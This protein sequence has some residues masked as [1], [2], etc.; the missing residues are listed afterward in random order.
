MS[1]DD[2]VKIVNAALAFILA[3]L[4][5]MAYIYFTRLGISYPVPKFSSLMGFTIGDCIV[6]ALACA[7]YYRFLSK[8]P[9]ADIL[10]VFISLMLSLCAMALG[11]IYKYG[12]ASLSAHIKS[13]LFLYII[14]FIGF[15]C[16]IYIALYELLCFVSANI[17]NNKINKKINTLLL[18][19]PILGIW[20]AGYFV[21]FFPG[22]MRW[23]SGLVI[24]FIEG[25]FAPRKVAPA[26]YQL[27]VSAFYYLGKLFKN[28]TIGLVCYFV[29]VGFIAAIAQARLIARAFKLNIS[30]F[31][32]YAFVALCAFSPLVFMQTFIM[33]YDSLLAIAMLYFA[34]D[35][36]DIVH[37]EYSFKQAIRLFFA[38]FF[39]CAFRNIGFAILESFI[40]VSAAYFIKRKNGFALIASMLVSGLLFFCGNALAFKLMGIEKEEQLGNASVALYQMGYTLNKHGSS[41]LNDS[42]KS[43]LAP[44]VDIEAIG[45]N[46]YQ[47]VS[48]SVKYQFL[49]HDDP[50]VKQVKEGGE[51][52]FYSVWRS[53]GKRYPKDYALAFIKSCYK[54]VIPGFFEETNDW[55][56][57]Q[58]APMHIDGIE[59]IESY[60]PLIRSDS[61]VQTNEGNALFAGYTTIYGAF[62]SSGYIF[63]TI[64]ISAMLVARK[65]GNIVP[66]LPA[67]IYSLGM[68]FSPVNGWLRYAVP[69]GFA[70]PICILLLFG[71]YKEKSNE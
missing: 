10:L 16:A 31:F 63:M 9:K 2:K 27:F 17:N 60:K 3:S 22:G 11:D 32:V 40:I 8:K 55:G 69:A 65:K 14:S 33:S 67:M 35:I 15:S 25:S 20:L 7:A 29:C 47:N 12:G 42:E 56:R 52:A 4:S 59:L 48:D 57:W 53:L 62:M 36:Y 66:M 39:L 64:F 30:R 5:V 46:Y 44:Y 24:G 13:S 70:I 49:Y 28:D 38:S 41:A 51:Q 18:A 6:L 71:A 19:L 45:G 61:N 58:H 68:L 21:F 34:I 43:L 26:F 54:F 37:E 23:E 50:Y 1:K